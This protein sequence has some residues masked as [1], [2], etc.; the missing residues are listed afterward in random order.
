MKEVTFPAFEAFLNKH[1]YKCQ[2]NQAI[3]QT[4]GENWWCVEKA[5]ISSPVSDRLQKLRVALAGVFPLLSLSFLSKI[6]SIQLGN[7]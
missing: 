3:S 6:K 1:Q 5:A 2:H 7:V 4:T